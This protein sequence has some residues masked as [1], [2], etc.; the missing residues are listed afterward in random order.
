MT[1]NMIGAYGEWAVERLRERVL[2]SRRGGMTELAEAIA[3]RTGRSEAEVMTT[4]V[5]LHDAS[6][7][8]GAD[9]N[10]HETFLRLQAYLRETGGRQ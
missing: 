3:A 8:E 2:P 5:R 1:P 6:H 9:E 10:A 7:G 4:L